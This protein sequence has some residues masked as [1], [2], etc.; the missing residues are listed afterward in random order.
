[1]LYLIS[2]STSPLRHISSGQLVNGGGFVHPERLLD[3]FVLILG[4]KG[5]V[6][7]E[8]DGRSYQISAN[9]YMIL[10]ASTPHR[11]N[12]PTQGGLSYYWCHFQIQRNQYRLVDE[13]S[14]S[15]QLYLIKNNGFFISDNFIIP[16]V[17]ELVQGARAILL[18]RQLLDASR[19]KSHSE[20]LSHYALS[21]LAMEISTDFIS[22]YNV[23]RVTS[24]YK[25]IA[26]IME[27]IRINYSN[28]LSC[29][30]VAEAF[31][32]NP[33]YLS[34][35]FKKYAG[36]SLIGYINR[37]KLNVAKKLLLGTNDPI[38]AIA[39][40][41]GYKDEKYFMKVFKQQEGVTPSQYRSAF[42]R[43]HMN[44]D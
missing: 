32:Y 7:I 37:T 9:Q 10:F 25:N 31:D 28:N 16:E 39:Y 2:P 29:V 27:W 40:A 38:N 4:D 34:N 20:Y 18:F 11:G 12:K 41:A 3:T 17:G 42:Y 35:A 6:H 36:V 22:G 30:R 8:Q 15:Q 21:L 23:D 19:R 5:T 24:T 13:D 1:M 14:I 33:N 26:E 44:R 43:K